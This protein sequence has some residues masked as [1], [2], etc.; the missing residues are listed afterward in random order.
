VQ[1]TQSVVPGVILTTQLAFGVSELYTD[2]I[3]S[4]TL[5]IEGLEEQ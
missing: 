2:F 1:L 5:H 4:V 3:P